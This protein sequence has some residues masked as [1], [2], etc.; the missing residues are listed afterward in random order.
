MS[1]ATANVDRLKLEDDR[2]AP[3]QTPTLFPRGL[4]LGSAERGSLQLS[5]L[6]AAFRIF[7]EIRP[8]HVSSGVTE[9]NYGLDCIHVY[10]L[11]LLQLTVGRFHP[12]H[13]PDRATGTLTGSFRFPP[14][15]QGQRPASPVRIHSGRLLQSIFFVS[16]KKKNSHD[17]IGTPSHQE[18]IFFF[19]FF[20]WNF[21][22]TCHLIR[23]ILL[24]VTSCNFAHPASF[25]L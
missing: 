13:T 8:N 3:G 1:T 6:R 24:R 12:I 20:C 17:I 5:R 7:L 22:Q 2:H 10:T 15:P 19:F 11:A 4:G 14:P 21:V 18:S 9:P 23:S 16:R 25:L